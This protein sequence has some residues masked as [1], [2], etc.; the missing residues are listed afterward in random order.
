MRLLGRLLAGA[1]NHSSVTEW[2]THFLCTF[3][4]AVS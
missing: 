3:L 1:Q 2:L 4:P